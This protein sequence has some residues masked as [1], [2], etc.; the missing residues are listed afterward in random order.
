MQRSNFNQKRRCPVV[1]AA[2]K[3]RLEPAEAYFS[4]LP[5]TGWDQMCLQYHVTPCT[6]FFALIM[7]KNKVCNQAHACFVFALLTGACAGT[8]CRSY[9]ERVP[10][11]PHI[12]S[13]TTWTFRKWN[14]H[15]IN[16]IQN[17]TIMTLCRVGRTSTRMCCEHIMVKS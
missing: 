17:W 3:G 1:G 4:A 11:V 12:D 14:W 2:A 10:C 13:D 6:L 8:L 7:P 16:N 15:S 5:C 9:S